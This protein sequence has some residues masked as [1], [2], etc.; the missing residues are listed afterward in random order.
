MKS[1]KYGNSTKGIR[2][3]TRFEFEGNEFDI[4]SEIRIALGS[5]K[6]L[7]VKCNPSKI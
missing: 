2:I 6:E 1:W 3:L 5:G 4:L 7:C